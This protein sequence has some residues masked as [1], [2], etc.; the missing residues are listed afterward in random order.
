MGS[1]PELAHIDLIAGDKEGPVGQAFAT[2]LASLAA[3]HTPVLAVIRPNLPAKPFTLIV[4]KVT[5]KGMDQATK[6]FGPAQAAVAKAIADAT[7]A[8]VVP[9]DQVDNIVIICSVFVHPDAKDYRRIYHYNYGA[10]RLALHR[11]FSAYPT[12]EKLTYD[13]D[14]AIHPIMGFK[15][16]RL[17]M[18]PYLQ[19]ALDVPDL[20]KT[21][22]IISKL[23]R[24]DRIILEAG[25]PLIK[26]Y[27][28]KVIHELRDVAKDIFIIADLKTLDVGQVEVDLA[29]DETADAVVAS[30]LAPKETIEA[31][32]HEAKRLGI[33]SFVDMMGVQDPL[34]TLRDLSEPPDVVVLHRGIDEE[35][36]R[37]SRW[38]A[39]R[40]IKG[41]RKSVV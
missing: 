13:K 21:R 5:V 16:P 7:E 2:G 4:P 3:G 37:E 36:V 22:E 31:F 29:Y 38:E 8:G 23:P 27:G 15:V 34:G 6:I 30:G 32:I 10:T 25:T 26:K 39:I 12:L 41:D 20:Q 19:I 9:R 17:W 18:P 35:R 33:Y 28:A 14:R 24:S 1:H 40:T 11:A